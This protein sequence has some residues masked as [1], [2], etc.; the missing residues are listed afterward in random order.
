MWVD[1]NYCES[2]KWEEFILGKSGQDCSRYKDE[3]SYDY[4]EQ[5]KKKVILD[6]SQIGRQ[7]WSLRNNSSIVSVKLW[8]EGQSRYQ[9]VWIYK[10]YLGRFCLDSI[11]IK[12]QGGCCF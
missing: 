2:L 12:G 7:G 5:E 11:R 10:R 6:K 8:G 4:R 1:N 9:K 3:I